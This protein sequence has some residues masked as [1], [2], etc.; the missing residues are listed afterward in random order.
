M[1]KISKKKKEEIDKEDERYGHYRFRRRCACDGCF[2][3]TI[4]LF[5]FTL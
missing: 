2:T 5:F 3:P 1:I 4:T